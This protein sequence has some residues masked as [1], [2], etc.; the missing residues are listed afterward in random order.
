[1]ITHP[2]DQITLS[3]AAVTVAAA[4]I[5]IGI[6]TM[7]RAG[8]EAVGTPDIWISTIIGGLIAIVVGYVIVKLSQKFPGKTFYEYSQLLTGSFLGRILGFFVIVYYTLL[9]AFE[10]RAMAEV[11]RTYLMDQTPIEV[12][13]IIFISVGAYL[14]FGGINSIVRLFELY[15]PVMAFFFFLIIA[16]SVG[17]VELDNLRPVLG[18]G[19]M[20]VAKGLEPMALSYLGVEVMLILTA[21]MKEPNKAQKAVFIGVSIMIIFY[22]AMIVTV[23]GALTVT[24]TKLLTWP[25]MELVKSIELKGFFFERF[26]TFFIMLWIL[27]TYTTFVI[28]FYLAALGLSQIFKQKINYFIYGL[29]PCMYIGAMYPENINSVFKLGDYLGYMDI[30]VAVIFPCVLWVAALVRRNRHE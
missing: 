4:I 16:L 20:P 17:N 21:F 9:A 5:G 7:P 19:I 23:I 24:E 22:L 8:A 26:E 11:T 6:I 14:V 13:V 10:A 3:Q 28:S 1:M 25:T 12:T 2:K 15:F 29:L 18:Q 30:V 27:T